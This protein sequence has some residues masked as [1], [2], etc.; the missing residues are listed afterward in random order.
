MDTEIEAEVDQAIK[1]CEILNRQDNDVTV[2][3]PRDRLDLQV[4]ETHA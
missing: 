2:Q 4:L 1:K 3:I